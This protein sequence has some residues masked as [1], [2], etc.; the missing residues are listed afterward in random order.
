LISIEAGSNTRIFVKKVTEWAEEN[1]KQEIF[2]SDIFVNIGETND[3]IIN[4]L[5]MM[6]KSNYTLYLNLYKENLKLQNQKL[7]ELIQKLSV[8]TEVD[9][10]PK[11]L[12]DFMD[13]IFCDLDIAYVIAPGGI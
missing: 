2:D 10:E 5:K 3:N 7:R 11:V 9:I 13:S 1:K 6:S 4:S 8:E 12:T